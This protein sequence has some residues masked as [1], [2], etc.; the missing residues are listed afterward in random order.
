MS[1]VYLSLGTN[2]GE[3]ELNLKSAI[4]EI[5]ALGSIIQISA[6]Y[7][8]E[9]WGFSSENKF[10]NMVVEIQTNIPACQLIK[11]CLNI[12][13]ILGRT[14]GS[15]WGYESRIID[16]DILFFG[17]EVVNQDKLTI[18]HPYIQERRFIL[19]PLNEIAPNLLHPVLCKTVSELL[20][21]CSDQCSV[22]SIGKIVF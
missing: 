9:P 4:K 7:E 16:I 5:G 8:T 17:D 11:E 20:L 22:Q 10:L 3:R 19:E 15:A 2:L 6:V 12:E 13:A 1:F 18:P 14:R 21:I